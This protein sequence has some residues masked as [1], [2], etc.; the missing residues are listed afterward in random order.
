MAARI[1]GLIPARGGSKG[2]PGK[3]T[4]LL[5]GL[6]LIQYTIQ[7]ALGASSLSRVTISTDDNEIADISR[8]AGADVP[9]L[10]PAALATDS[11]PTIDTVKHCLEYYLFKG[12]RFD[13]VCLLQPT[14]PFRQTQDIE[15]A[16]KEFSESGADSLISVKEIPAKF[17]PH[18]AFVKNEET[19]SFEIATGES[20]IIPRRQELPPAY[21]RDGSIYIT[22]SEVILNSNSLYGQKIIA[23]E[24][25]GTAD[26][27]IDS[28]EDWASAEAY[29]TQNE[30]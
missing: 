25:T 12:E 24:S 16:L 21:Y 1:L 11:S 10:R 23:Y 17:N 26:I 7:A 14:V 13:A 4:K 20:Q 8:E 29:M 19:G 22:R 2:V 5:G 27:N 3:N 30:G 15:A 6:P 9:F 18:W 28:P